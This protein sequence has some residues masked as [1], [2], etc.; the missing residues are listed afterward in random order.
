MANQVEGLHDTVGEIDVKIAEMHAIMTM[1][2]PGTSPSISPLRK[3]DTLFSTTDTL[4][5]EL[6][7]EAS[8]SSSGYG[9][10]LKPEYTLPKSGL[11]S[12][13]EHG[14]GLFGHKKR[15]TSSRNSIRSDPQTSGV[16]TRASVCYE[17]L[18]TGI[19]D[20]LLTLSEACEAS[21]GTSQ[22]L[23]GAN[24]IA[25]LD[26]PQPAIS[27]SDPSLTLRLPSAAVHSDPPEI[28]LEDYH[29]TSEAA[30]TSQ[31][32]NFER[33]VLENAVMLCQ[34]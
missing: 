22:S 6:S 25:Q 31:Q 18:P 5:G 19:T 26:L 16:S 9:E 7:G 4:V 27:P 24:T 30:S 23:Q 20:S 15:Q 21:C 12:S 32:K 11:S 17:T 14:E 34:R 29:R 33:T 3:R 10:I 2:S 28:I 13:P 8:R 1:S